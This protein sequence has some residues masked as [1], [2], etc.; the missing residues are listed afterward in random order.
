M[1]LRDHLRVVARATGRLPAQLAE[2][3][4]H[5]AIRPLQAVFAELAATRGS[6]GFG[7][8]PLAPSEVQAWAAAHGVSFTPWE[9]ET[10]LA[11]DRAALQALLSD[12]PSDKLP[13]DAE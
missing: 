1:P 10:L 13:K 4:L 11:A 12:R 2:P 3:P 6:N 7:L 5:P 8:Q 9:F